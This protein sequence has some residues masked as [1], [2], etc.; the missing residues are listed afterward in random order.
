MDNSC[1]IWWKYLKNLV[2]YIL[3]N[4][5]SLLNFLLLNILLLDLSSGTC[6]VVIGD[7]TKPFT[8]PSITIKSFFFFFKKVIFLIFFFSFN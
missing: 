2:I 5:N 6:V 3:F 8:P 7:S 1:Q 4:F